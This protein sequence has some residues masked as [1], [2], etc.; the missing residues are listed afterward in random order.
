MCERRVCRKWV[1]RAVVS[2][3]DVIGDIQHRHH[4][5]PTGSDSSFCQEKVLFLVAIHIYQADRRLM[6]KT[7]Y[8]FIVT[9]KRTPVTNVGRSYAG[10]T[11]AL[12][13]WRQI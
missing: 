11:T 8:R 5:S 10:M 6:F 9:V 4:T 12:S 2:L 7:E 13:P 3:R 1:T